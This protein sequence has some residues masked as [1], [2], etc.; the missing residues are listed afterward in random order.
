MPGD[1]VEAAD[2][3]GWYVDQVREHICP[4][5]LATDHTADFHGRVSALHLGAVQIGNFTFSPLQAVRTARHVRRGDPEMYQ[6]G[7]MRRSP[8]RVR[9]LRNDSF[10]GTGDMVLFDTSHPLEAEVSEGHEMAEVTMLRIPRNALPMNPDH[11]DR[12]LALRLAA[13]AVTGALLRRHVDTLLSRAAEVGPAESH[14]LGTLTADLVAAFVADRLDRA[15][16][17]PAETRSAVLRAEINAFINRHLGDPDLRP[18]IIAAH[19][20]ISLRTLHDLFRHEPDTLAA[21]IR[22]RRME[23]CRTDLADPRLRDRPIGALAARWG[24]ALPAEFSRAFRAVYGLSPSEY[25]AWAT[26]G[27]ESARNHKP[28]R[29][30]AQGRPTGPQ[31]HGGSEEHR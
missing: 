16:L 15:D 3:F 20:H 22:H 23:R 7:W 21:T 9:Q 30:R 14:R 25:R 6:L 28:S 17:L 1:A 5:A 27:M 18:A 31:H 2:R 29:T 11:A 19:H 12:V 13:D 4:I 8:I 26:G 24:F 10:V